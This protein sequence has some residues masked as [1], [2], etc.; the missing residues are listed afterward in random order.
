MFPV[1]PVVP[2]AL[3]TSCTVIGVVNWRRLRRVESLLDRIE[4]HGSVR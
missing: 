3:L 4:T 2:I 1:M